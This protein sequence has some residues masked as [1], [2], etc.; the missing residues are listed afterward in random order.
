M[1]RL[2]VLFAAILV[3]GCGDEQSRSDSR[4]KRLIKMAV[5]EGSLL[6]RDDRMYRTN[7]SEP[8]SGWVKSMYES[9]QVQGLGKFKD[10]KLNG[11][12]TFWHDNGQKR[13]E[14][15]YKDG[16]EVSAKYWNGKGEEVA[17][18]EETDK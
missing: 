2:V 7:E 5:E 11:L 6:K 1:K 17:T 4:V 9:G 3:A 13:A 15:T 8:Y 10:G 18:K 12:A 16:E 14:V